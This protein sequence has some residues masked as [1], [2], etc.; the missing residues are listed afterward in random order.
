MPWFDRSKVPWAPNWFQELINKVSSTQKH[1]PMK[2][3][4]C[5]ELPGQVL[6][7]LTN[8]RSGSTWLFDALRCHPGIKFQPRATINEYLG[9]NCRRYPLGLSNTPEAS[10]NI[11]V[12]PGRW[13][14]IPDFSIKTIRIWINEEIL[15]SPYAIEK[16]HPH[17][18]DHDVQK[19][20][21]KIR[22]LENRINIKFLYLIRDPKSSMVS[23]LNYQR[24][25]PNW[26]AKIDNE[27]LPLH[28]FRIYDSILKTAKGHSG[29]I[30]DYREL[31]NN[32][33]SVLNRIIDYLWP[34]IQN[35][36]KENDRKLIELIASLTNREKRKAVNKDFLGDKPGPVSGTNGNHAEFF[37][38]HSEEINRC[39]NV[40]SSL[41]QLASQ[42][43]EDT[44]P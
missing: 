21:Q 5:R 18:F 32:F 20:M 41:L 26:N 22:E 28:M 15:H 9:L 19:F 38:K 23:F 7:L 30:I 42:N 31:I 2:L 25:N 37:Y 27:I 12:R 33:H 11:E 24:R 6:I 34:G 8:P 44:L 40:Y 1:L 29:L 17:H 10:L 13:E 4:H 36:D 3:R 14:K 35:A 43:I 39:Y 16:F